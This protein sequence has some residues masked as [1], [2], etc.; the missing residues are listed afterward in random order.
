[1][2]PVIV[3]IL[4]SLCFS[5]SAKEHPVESPQRKIAIYYTATPFKK[6]L[7]ARIIKEC[8][9]KGLNVTSG[10]MKELGSCILDE[11]EAVI[12][13]SQVEKFSPLSESAR[14]IKKNNY[15]KKIIY[16]STYA[17]FK[18]HYGIAGTAL[19]SKKIDVISAASPKDEPKDYDRQE[20]DK[21]YNGIM[22]KLDE[23]L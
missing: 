23:L 11:Y 8:N 1:M 15:S 3:L 17:A 9:A 18:L 14:F 10:S 16:V 22:A 12:I 19:D 6:D 7:A 4:L 5:L 21:A 20:V 2:R 13:L